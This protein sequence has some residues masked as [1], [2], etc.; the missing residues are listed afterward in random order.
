MASIGYGQ[1]N[2]GIADYGTPEYEF[3]SATIAQTDYTR[4][5]QE[6]AQQRKAI[7]AQQHLLCMLLGVKDS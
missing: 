3:A 5:T 2:Y 4:K 1:L 6:L 7:E